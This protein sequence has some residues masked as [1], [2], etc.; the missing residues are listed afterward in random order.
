MP[1]IGSQTLVTTSGSHVFAPR[2]VDP[3]TGI[4]TLVESVGGVPL[5]E[6]RIA[7]ARSRTN[8]GVNKITYK[9][10]CPVVSTVVVG[11]VSQSTLLRTAYAEISFS[12]AGDSTLDERV[13]L[14]E[15]VAACMTGAN[16]YGDELID[17]LEFLY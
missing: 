17:N 6:R 9:I 11:G 7:I 5:A 10:T 1:S 14:R 12:F 4:A 15:L 13:M 3:K 2:G 16:T 8:N